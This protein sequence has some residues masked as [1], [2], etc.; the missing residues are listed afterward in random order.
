MMKRSALSLLA[1]AILFT[2]LLAAADSDKDGKHRHREYK[3]EYWDGHCK[4]ER[5]WKKN[6][7][8]KEKRKCKDD[9][10]AYYGPAPMYGP[11]P[12]YVPAPEPGLVIQGTVRVK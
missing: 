4:V 5:K 3:D 11:A 2:P 9:G 1:G 12:V 10:P 7:E 8:Y 6:G